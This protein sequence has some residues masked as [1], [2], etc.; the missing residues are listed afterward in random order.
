MSCTTTTTWLRVH[1]S[2]LRKTSVAAAAV[3]GVVLAL[4][5]TLLASHADRAL[6]ASQHR[7]ANQ[8]PAKAGAYWSPTHTKAGLAKIQR[9]AAHRAARATA[10]HVGSRD[11]KFGAQPVLSYRGV[12]DP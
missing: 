11:R 8:R 7:S 9:Q 10:W 6:A 3:I 4:V 2:S 1:I 5:M 12:A